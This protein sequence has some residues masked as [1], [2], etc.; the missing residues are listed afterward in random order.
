MLYFYILNID[1]YFYFYF[2]FSSVYANILDNYIYSNS[3]F[4]VWGQY[5]CL[6]LIKN[7]KNIE[8]INIGN[9][10]K[11]WQ[12]FLSNQKNM[13]LRIFSYSIKDTILA[14]TIQKIYIQYF[15]ATLALPTITTPMIWL[16][17]TLQNLRL[18]YD[19]QL[20]WRKS[21]QLQKMNI[22]IDFQYFWVQNG[23]IKLIV[24]MYILQCH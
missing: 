13:K 17:I 15:N 11:T 18:R 12:F 19:W 24:I 22:I 7:S 9:L 6:Y 1:F 2:Y 23:T 4:T 10:I 8:Y 5:S 14:I 21:I 3:F 20:K 16:K